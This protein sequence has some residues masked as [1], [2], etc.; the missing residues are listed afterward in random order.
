M[1]GPIVTE[2]SDCNRGLSVD[3]F[4]WITNVLGIFCA[5][6]MKKRVKEMKASE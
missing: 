1:V 6:C 4:N 3:K 2:C 5:E